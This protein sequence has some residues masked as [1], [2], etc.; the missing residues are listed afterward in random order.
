MDN[1]KKKYDDLKQYIKIDANYNSMDSYRTSYN[2]LSSNLFSFVTSIQNNNIITRYQY[3]LMA[4]FSA[5]VNM[6]TDKLN[7]FLSK[8]HDISN[9]ISDINDAY[10]EYNSNMNILSTYLSSF[11]LL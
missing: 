6:V 2:N 7:I 11:P 9:S 10:S 8:I 4:N 3:N 5:T 1:I